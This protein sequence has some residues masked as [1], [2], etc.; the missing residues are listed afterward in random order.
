[1]ARNYYKSWNRSVQASGL[2]YN[3]IRKD[4]NNISWS[5]E[6]VLEKIRLLADNKEIL[7]S[8]YNSVNQKKLWN[9]AN[10]Y[11]YSW[12]NAVEA[13]NINYESISEKILD[14]S[15]E[16]VKSEILNIYNN[17]L[18]LFASYAKN[19]YVAL[20]GAASTFNGG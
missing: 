8:K 13:A 15:A 17:D 6:M 18:P 14:W 1:M 5:K 11:F 2:Y 16:K 7:S 12:R 4:K 10:H 20:Y 9:A 19:N 3:R